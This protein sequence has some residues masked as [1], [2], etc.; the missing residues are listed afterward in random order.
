M[1]ARLSPLVAASRLAG[2]LVVVLGLV[3]LA[4]WFVRLIAVVQLRSYLVP[5][6]PNTALGLLVAGAGLA[7]L[8]W[9]RR[10]FALACAA[11]AGALGLATMVQYGSGVDLGID[12]LLVEPFVTV[13]TFHPGRMS[14]P[15]ALGFV[16][17]GAALAAGAGRR[18]AARGPV[19]GLLG[20][21]AL[22]LG[23]ATL[24]GY[25]G[26]FEIPFDWQAASYMAPHTAAGF[27][28]VGAGLLALAWGRVT[29]DTGESPR[30]A[31]LA[32]ALTV[33]IVAAALWQVTVAD[34]RA[35]IADEVDDQ[36]A[37]LVGQV[38]GLLEERLLSFERAAARWR[39][40]AEAGEETAREGAAVHL[41]HHP[42]L[43]AIGRLA[44]SGMPRWM[45]HR[46]GAGAEPAVEEPRDPRV[47]SAIE[48]ALATRRLALRTVPADA[49]SPAGLVAVV[50]VAPGGD[51]LYCRLSL[52]GLRTAPDRLGLE[53]ALYEDERRVWTTPGMAAAVGA[54]QER[55][56]DLAVRDRVW[57]VRLRPTRE[58][59]DRAS[60]GTPGL[61]VGA[62]AAV[63]LLLTLTTRFAQVARRQ[64]A[65]LA[66]ANRVLERE[67]AGRGQAEQRVRDLNRSLSERVLQLEGANRELETFSYSV[68]HDLRAPLRHLSGFADL[69]GEEAADRLD[70]RSRRYLDVIREAA[71]KM[72][73]LIDE[74]LE[75]SRAGRA[76]L[77]ARAV[78]LNVLVGEVI[79]TVQPGAE[80][81]IEW[82]VGELPEVRADPV[83]LRT[84]VQNLLDNAVKFT[85][86]C[87]PARIE[88]S[89]DSAN[90]QG[91]AI[92]VRDNGV[93]F[94]PR[95]TGKLF[96]I[97]QRL[98]RD[99]EF[100]GTGVGLANVQ[101]II[102]RHGGTVWAEGELG[103]GATFTFTLPAP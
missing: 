100:E 81:R 56:L 89:A 24:V 27:A 65:R 2:G 47:V 87:S 54:T 97:F 77:N 30:W 23:A 41:E 78:D 46:D 38:E 44:P 57:Q 76:E 83:L 95:Y 58:L 16:L 35:T 25:A 99:D 98:H 15:T 50:P 43:V 59:F 55:Q 19:S 51:L 32:V 85:R 22:G 71:G 67:V 3:V 91:C 28:V 52:D 70:E 103:V 53:A 9:D 29:D 60:S 17:I 20:T 93:G 62:G 45:L 90:E 92:R 39:R 8:S 80:R 40:G 33:G 11:A 68:S 21:L 37:I 63:T 66:E 36:S 34:E 61:A 42:D 12:R 10:R 79:G 5:M 74:L 72:G 4:G 1:A 14:A 6:Q 18:P 94:D 31:P 84:V 69:L 49:S 48:Q 73:R 88:I 102:H 101:R 26:G 75:F 82:R 7:A 13:K 64:A 96:G 86:G